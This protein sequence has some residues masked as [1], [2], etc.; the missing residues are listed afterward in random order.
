MT[1]RVDVDP[2]IG[3]FGG[4]IDEARAAFAKSGQPQKIRF[5]KLHE[6]AVIPE[7]KSEEAAGMDLRSVGFYNIPASSVQIID[8]GLAMSIPRGYEGQI[9]PRSGLAANRRVTVLNAPGTI[10]WL[11]VVPSSNTSNESASM[12][13]W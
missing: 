5:K 3:F 11:A 12:R 8:T 9:R 1:Q 10:T 4:A 2:D 13:L 7:Y 6:L